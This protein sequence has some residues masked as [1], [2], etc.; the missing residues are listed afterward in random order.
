MS[1]TR[2]SFRAAITSAV[3]SVEPSDA[4][5]ISSIKCASSL[6]RT[7]AIFFGS[8]PASLCPMMSTDNFCVFGSLIVVSGRSRDN[9]NTSSG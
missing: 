8:R 9:A 5:M 7:L 1:F 3:S 2:G 4:T 6:E